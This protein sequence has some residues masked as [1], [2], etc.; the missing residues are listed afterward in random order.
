ML[1]LKLEP[2]EDDLFLKRIRGGVTVG[3]G[4]VRSEGCLLLVLS[5]TGMATILAL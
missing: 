2:C 5:I 3:V 1:L 4:G